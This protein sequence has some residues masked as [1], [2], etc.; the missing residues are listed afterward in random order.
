MAGGPYI[1]ILLVPASAFT[2]TGDYKEFVTTAASGNSMHRHFCP[3]CG[4]LLFVRNSGFPEVRPIAA[5]TLDDPSDF[6]PEKDMW[7][8]DAQPWDLMDPKL[9][10]FEGNPW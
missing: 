1:A 7:V 8:A 3:E 10:K 6:K 2:I 9:P 4:S 5:V